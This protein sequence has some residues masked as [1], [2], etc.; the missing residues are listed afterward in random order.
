MIYRFY[1]WRLKKD[2]IPSTT[3][4]LL[5]CLPHLFQLATVYIVLLYFF[6]SLKKI[7]LTNFQLITCLIRFQLLY[8]VIVYNK[9][10]WMD[11]IEEFKNET[12]EQRKKRTTLIIIYT[13]GTYLLFFGGLIILF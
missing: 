3:V 4:E 6:P 9:K 11:Y 2:N 12:D 7:N 10:R 8:H 1:S 5:M 13:I